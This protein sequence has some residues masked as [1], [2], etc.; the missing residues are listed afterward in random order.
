M[1]VKDLLS[2]CNIEDLVATMAELET[3]DRKK[4]RK[5]TAKFRI[6]CENLQKIEPLPS[7]YAMVA[8]KYY[9]DDGDMLEVCRY[10]QDA[11][12]NELVRS[13]RLDALESVASLTDKEILAIYSFSQYIPR[14]KGFLTAPW[15]EVLSDLVDE[16]NVREVGVI[17]FLAEIF[18]ELAYFGRSDSE[19]E[20]SRKEFEKIAEAACKE[21]YLTDAEGVAQD[22][23]LQEVG[24]ETGFVQ[25]E[26]LPFVEYGYK[27]EREEIAAQRAARR[28]WLTD[29]LPEY[30]ALRQFQDNCLH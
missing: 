11:I 28:H 15:A 9:F 1:I 19:V 17:P 22:I 6:A 13:E 23:A 12:A 24:E 2:V 7:P 21:G 5:L 20:I 14:S 26:D 16:E 29:L 18:R 10:R 8:H 27:N 4:R 25:E 3:D 30:K